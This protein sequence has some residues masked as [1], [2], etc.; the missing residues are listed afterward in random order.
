MPLPPKLS[1]LLHISRFKS[2]QKVASDCTVFRLNLKISLRLRDPP[3]IAIYHIVKY[4]NVCVAYGFNI[5]ILILP[6]VDR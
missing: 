1:K 4:N 3:A 2:L 5:Y 6:I